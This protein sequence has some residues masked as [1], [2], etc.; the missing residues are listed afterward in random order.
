MIVGFNFNSMNVKVNEDKL[1]ARGITVNSVPSVT[2]LEKAEVLNMK[3]IL[4]V[5]FRFEAKY[6]PDVGEIVMDGSLL[7]RDGDAKKALKLW[8][9]EK[10]M[11]S[12]SGVEVINT[13]FRRCL[14]KAVV[15]AEDV[16]LPPPVQFPMVRATE[17]KPEE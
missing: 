15:L 5:K 1:S 9:E 14:A 16:R 10:K 12:K 3:D 11:E 17:K 2:D 4:R 6:E 13:I 7:W 8:E